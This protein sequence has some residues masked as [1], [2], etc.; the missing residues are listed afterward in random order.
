MNAIPAP[1]AP[2]P[3]GS[4]KRGTRLGYAAL[5]LI[6]FVASVRSA[7]PEP[8]QVVWRERKVSFTYSS[9][10]TVYSCE[11]LARRVSSI[12]RALGARDDVKV[13]VTPCDT[14]S[15]P[16]GS[17]VG[18]ASRTTWEPE[19]GVKSDPRDTHTPDRRP[20]ASVYVRAMMPTE[21][22]EEILA[23]L[24]KEQSRRELVAHVTGNA[25]ARFDN[26]VVF[27]AQRQQVTLSRKTIGLESQECE[28]LEQISRSIF[29][30]LGIKLMSKA[31]IC[32]G[33][34]R[35]PPELI[36]EALIA[37]PYVAPELPPIGTEV[38]DPGAPAPSDD[39]PASPPADQTPK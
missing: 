18:G 7:E 2:G 17:H 26:P 19:P 16:M 1:N 32:N 11:S 37:T 13:N 23:E 24:K 20:I 9:Y 12:L 10:S 22:T 35:L 4:Q 39:A 6:T 31:F 36:A 21:I 5:A 25:S 29:R 30:P 38:P 28:L 15:V 8:I 27:N 3:A 34:S 14:S 33:D